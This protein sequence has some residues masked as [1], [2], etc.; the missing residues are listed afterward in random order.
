MLKVEHNVASDYEFGVRGPWYN[1]LSVGA[2]P[3][4][5]MTESYYHC[6]HELV[7]LPKFES[8]WNQYSGWKTIEVRREATCEVCKTYIYDVQVNDITLA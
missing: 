4:S 6:G 3:I 7:T 5:S 2:S 8:I 1:N